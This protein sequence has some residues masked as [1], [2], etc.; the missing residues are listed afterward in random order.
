MKKGTSKIKTIS[1][2]N[3]YCAI[4]E[5]LLDEV[6]RIITLIEEYDKRRNTFK[7]SSP[8]LILTSLCK[9]HNLSFL[10]LTNELGINGSEISEFLYHRGKLSN[11]TIKALSNYFKVYPSAF[12]YKSKIKNKIKSKQNAKRR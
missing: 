3:K 12:K 6:R 4:V 5:Y 10:E 11:K 1:E 9:N 2:Y 8:R 7:T